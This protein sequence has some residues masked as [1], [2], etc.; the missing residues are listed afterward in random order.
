MSAVVFETQT[1]TPSTESSVRRGIQTYV[2][3]DP[4]PAKRNR[5]PVSARVRPTAD[6]L[7][8]WLG[9]QHRMATIPVIGVVNGRTDYI[10]EVADQDLRDENGT[11]TPI[12]LFTDAFRRPGVAFRVRIT[13]DEKDGEITEEAIYV[14]FQRYSD[15][16]GLWVL[17]R[18]HA[19]KKGLVSALHEGRLDVISQ[20]N[21]AIS[22]RG[23]TVLTGLFATHFTDGSA[24][25]ID[26]FQMRLVPPV[27]R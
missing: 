6:R 26:E 15:S 24:Y 14:A 2:L 25:H 3:E 1:T 11:P 4:P 10:D 27:M 22:Q 19:T 7:S 18:S 8:Q 23:D 17:C 13:S 12:A 20:A 16:D 9:G 21:T 5:I